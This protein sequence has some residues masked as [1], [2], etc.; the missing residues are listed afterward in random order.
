MTIDDA[1]RRVARDGTRL[2]L[3]SA[4]GFVIDATTVADDGLLEEFY[5]DYD[6]AFVLANEKEGYAGFAECLALNAG[7]GYVDLVRQYGPFREF[8]AVA[9]DP[10]T[11]D[12]VGGAN[13]IVFPVRLTAPAPSSVL[14]VNLNYVFI[15]AGKR[16]QGSFRR[17]VNDLPDA[18]FRLL[19]ETNAY[20]LPAEWLA[21]ASETATPPPQVY[22]FIEQNDPFRMSPED[23]KRDTEY[24]GL[25]QIARI[26]MWAQ[27]GA[28]IIDFPYVQ[29][30]LSS[31]QQPDENLVY[32]VLGAREE[33]LDACLLCLHLER[34]FAISVLKGKDISQQPCASKQIRELADACRRGTRFPLLNPSALHSAAPSAAGS[35][36]L[37]PGSLRDYLKATSPMTTGSAAS[38]HLE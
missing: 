32:A 23:Y 22:V 35:S 12:R 3:T 31:D 33:T 18:A 37:G 21:S 25:D 34:F 15:N 27:L 30:P 36:P 19:A 8:V 17:L 9:R 14:S 28:K 1:G 7:D 13:F 6:R 20:D 5:A 10:A 29:P 24:T 38:M 16:Q 4:T 11:G 2:R 26:R